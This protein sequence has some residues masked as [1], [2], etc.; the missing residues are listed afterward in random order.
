M[1]RIRIGVIG[2]LHTHWD[3]MDVAQ[4]ARSDYDLL[5]FTG[6]LGGGTRESC[7]RAAK[8]MSRLSKRAF[9]MPGNNDTGDIAQLG[10]ELAYRSGIKTLFAIRQGTADSDQR[11]DAAPI[12]LCGYSNHRLT[13]G[14]VDLTLIAGRPHSMGGNE[15]SFPDHMESTYGIGSIAA[16]TAR[17]PELVSA[18]ETQDIVFLS[19]NGPT[20][21]GDA[22]HDMWGCDFKP[23]G[24][25]WGD[26]DLA[27]AIDYALERGK[28]VLAV[29]AGHMHL[30]TKCGNERPWRIERNGIVYINAARVPRIFSRNAEVL[31]HHV[32]VTVTADGIEVD[33]IFVPERRAL[34]D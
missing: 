34:P 20:G 30:H 32:A 11:A 8:A 6:D 24:G 22:P 17:L 13:D 2:D 14:P 33:E 3:D 31:R 7:L 23:G 16:S 4:F 21:L 25:D 28:R 5:L 10:A 27:A 1:A 19:H 26:P 29:I 18:T 12:R 15:L 9:V